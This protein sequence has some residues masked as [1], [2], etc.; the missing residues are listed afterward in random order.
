MVSEWSHFFA[1]NFIGEPTKIAYFDRE[2]YS[3]AINRL[4]LPAKP[5]HVQ[6]YINSIN[7]VVK[8]FS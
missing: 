4:C 2:D 1:L 8:I 6:G 3:V 5:K 7:I